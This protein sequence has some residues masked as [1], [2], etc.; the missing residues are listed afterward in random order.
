MALVVYDR[1]QQTGSAN[2]T[3]SFTLSATT[4]GYQSF[5]VVGNGNTTYY[6]ANDGTNW[7]VGIGT[8]STTGP[9]LTRTTILSSS[10]S[11]SAVST[12]GS[13]VTV[14][15]DYTA[16]KSVMLDASGFICGGGQYYLNFNPLSSAPSAQTGLTWYDSN[17]DSFAYYNSTGYEINPGQQVDTICYNNTGSSIPANTSVYFVGGSSGNYPYIAPAIATSLNTSNVIGVTGQSIANGATGAVVALGIIYSYNTTGLAAGAPLYLSPSTAG[18]LTTTEP[19]SPYYAVRVGYVLAGNSSTGSI[20]VSKTNM[21]TLG[22]NIISP[23]TFTAFS[24]TSTVLNLTGLSG[25]I[26]DLFD[27]NTSTGN[28]FKINNVGA[29]TA[30]NTLTALATISS[31]GLNLN[32]NTVSASYSIPSGYSASSVGPITIASGQTVTVPSGS[33]WVIS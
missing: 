1:I 26:A 12:F 11:G 16:E 4:A 14:F 13:T 8:Y 28:V 2:T 27:V 30:T 21:Y 15:C 32:S 31:N 3:V 29:I 23:V 10:N 7:E 6:S 9:T 24:T 19:T 18:A 33:R 17:R 20:F 5:A 25:Q 22:S